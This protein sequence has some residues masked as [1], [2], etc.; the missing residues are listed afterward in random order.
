MVGVAAPHGWVRLAQR[1]TRLPPHLTLGLG[2]AQYAKEGAGL[3][4]GG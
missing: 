4:P 2:H 1:G 3:W